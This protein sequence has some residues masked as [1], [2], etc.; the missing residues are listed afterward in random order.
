MRSIFA[1]TALICATLAP[2][3]T[4]APAAAQAALYSEHYYRW[5]C[6]GSNGPFTL[7]LKLTVWPGDGG[8][9]W[10]PGVNPVITS[11]RTWGWKFYIE[12]RASAGQYVYAF[13]GDAYG[14]MFWMIAPQ[15]QYHRFD[16]HF[17]YRDGGFVIIGDPI[18]QR[19]SHYSESFCQPNDPMAPPLGLLN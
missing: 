12:G 16:A 18:Y 8:V 3:L 2:A 6:N 10:S 14:G 1:L 7:D 15:G 5:A 9:T 19:A 11:A 13:D 4:P 17:Y